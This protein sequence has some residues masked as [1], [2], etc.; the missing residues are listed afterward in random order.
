MPTANHD[1][2]AANDSAWFQPSS[3]P[4]VHASLAHG[5]RSLEEGESLI[6]QCENAPE[7]EVAPP[8]KPKLWNRLIGRGTKDQ[9]E[10][11]YVQFMRSHNVIM[12]ECIGGM[13]FGGDMQWTEADERLLFHIGW[14]PWPQYGH[15]NYV[16]QIPPLADDDAEPPEYAPGSAAE[17][18][19][20]LAVRTM[21]DVLEVTPQDL[22]A[23]IQRNLAS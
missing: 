22:S 18:A 3:W 10:K 9:G 16:A 4:Q 12:C 17:E 15:P 7:R 13:H 5:L 8:P 21:R 2:S 11:P 19:A 1:A 20:H 6:V 14:Q 23:E